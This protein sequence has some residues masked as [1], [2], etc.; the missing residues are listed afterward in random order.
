MIVYFIDD[1]EYIRDSLELNFQNYKEIDF[2]TF[3][4]YNS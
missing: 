3:D 1:E 4:N 2:Y